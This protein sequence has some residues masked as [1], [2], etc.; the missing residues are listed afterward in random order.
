MNPKTEH[1]LRTKIVI[2]TVAVIGFVL[3]ALVAY[4][5][6][7]D[8][9][10]EFWVLVLSNLGSLLLVSVAIT[11]IYDKFIRQA[12][13]AEMRKEL[14][15][16]YDNAQ[17]VLS[18][19]LIEYYKD[20]LTENHLKEAFRDA[21][22]QICILQVWSGNATALEGVIKKAIKRGCAIK[23]LL[24]N[25]M[26][27]QC[28]Y[29]SRDLKKPDEHA[30]TQISAE[31]TTYQGILEEDPINKEFFELKIYDA[32][33]T[34]PMFICDE[35][36]FFGLMWREN[37]TIDSPYFQAASRAT[38]LG[39]FLH[40]HFQSLWNDDRTIDYELVE[41]ANCSNMKHGLN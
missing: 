6:N 36:V 34:V 23:I 17:K 11:L 5:K 10:K 8:D 28:T 38:D 31:L 26:S 20:G 3:M 40:N 16:T 37:L 14:Q 22:E 9:W 19:G 12:Y 32:T 35:S 15:D 29:R 30:K 7:P 1:S 41:D 13:L 25:P 39:R 18:S 21:T 27:D 24:L 33:P 4:I 2:A